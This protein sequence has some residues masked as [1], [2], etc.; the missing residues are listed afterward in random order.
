M[1]GI[2]QGNDDLARRIDERKLAEGV[3]QTTI[4]PYFTSPTMAGAGTYLK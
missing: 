1:V 2:C 4:K 3:L